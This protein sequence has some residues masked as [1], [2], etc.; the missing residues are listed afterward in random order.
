MFKL[1]LANRASITAQD[2]H[3]CSP[4]ELAVESENLAIVQFLLQHGVPISAVKNLGNSPLHV[5]TRLNCVPMISCLLAAGAMVDKP[6]KDGI[7]SLR[8][9]ALYEQIEVLQLL[10]KTR[11][12]KPNPAAS[13]NEPIVHPLFCR[14]IN[15]E[16]IDA[17]GKNASSPGYTS[18]LEGVCSQTFAKRCF[19]KTKTRSV[20][21]AA[22]RRL[23]GQN[24]DNRPYI[25]PPS[26]NG[27]LLEILPLHC[28]THSCT[29]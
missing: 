22:L 11:D 7:T 29:K 24:M 21:R 27:S 19:H 14:V 8:I 1:I 20:E 18:R 15:L 17:S 23:F 28:A 5:A 9:C 16:A 3:G 10:L 25:G 2:Q 12:N 13:D 4:L 26:E 6:S